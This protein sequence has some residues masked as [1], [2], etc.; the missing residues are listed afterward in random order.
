MDLPP[1]LHPLDPHRITTLN[2][3]PLDVLGVILSMVEGA[4]AYLVSDKSK[5]ARTLDCVRACAR[6]A[7]SACAAQ[8]ARVG[9][10]EA[11]FWK[12]RVKKI[13]LSPPPLLRCETPASASPTRPTKSLASTGSR[14]GPRPAG[15]ARA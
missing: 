7:K 4:Y 14:A 3:L 8:G 1:H 10:G 6:R 5:T 11:W 2:D 13:D 15:A 9:R 12:Q